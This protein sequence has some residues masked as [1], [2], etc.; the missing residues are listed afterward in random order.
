[1]AEENQFALQIC[2]PDRLLF[3]GNVEEITAP[4]TDG[5]FGVLAGHTNFVTSL[6]S[7]E[8][9]YYHE[10]QTHYVAVRG[11]FAEVTPTQVTIV[12]DVAEK[13]EEIHAD[14]VKKAQ[15]EAKKAMAGVAMED[16]GYKDLE[17]KLAWEETR[18]LVCDRVKG[19]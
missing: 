14:E 18:L 19:D 17:T 13:A 6:R 1:M 15:E 11:G 2:T 4:G 5:V 12:A 8:V 9:F 7:G 10:G 16:P 3:S